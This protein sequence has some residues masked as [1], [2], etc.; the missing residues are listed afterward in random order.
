MKTADVA[1]EF[2]VLGFTPDG[3]MW[4]FPDRNSLT[5]CGPRTLKQDMERDME[6]VDAGGRRW[7]VRSIRRI[8]LGYPL[9]PWLFRSLLSTPQYRIEHD[10]PVPDR[11]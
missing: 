5:S 3:E 4:G 8:G 7:I 1:F 9:I 10:A 6:L 11:A 2:P